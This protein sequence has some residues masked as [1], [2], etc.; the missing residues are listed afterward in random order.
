MADPR[1]LFAI[2]VS[3]VDG[4]PVTRFG[5]GTLIGASR[6]KEAPTLVSYDPTAVVGIP[7]A[8]YGQHRRAYDRALSNGSLRERTDADYLAQERAQA[9]R[10]EDNRQAKLERAK[11]AAQAAQAKPAA[12]VS[13]GLNESPA[14]D[15]PA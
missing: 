11:L 6:T 3:C 13:L 10:D 4:Q 8:E 2:F 9:K 5:T 1:A 15:P 14:S 12:A 7:H